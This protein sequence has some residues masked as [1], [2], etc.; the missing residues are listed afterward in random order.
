VA[1]ALLCAVDSGEKDEDV[2][3]LFNQNGMVGWGLATSWATAGLALGCSVGCCGLPGKPF[4][5]YFL[6]SFHFPFSI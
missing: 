6:F 3:L 2:R 5:L 4:S 1:D